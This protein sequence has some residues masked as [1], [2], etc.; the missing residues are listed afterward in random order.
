MKKAI[1]YLALGIL[2][3]AGQ[4]CEKD[5]AFSFK[6]D[7]RIYFSYPRAL[8]HLGRE[9]DK[10][11]DSLNFSFVTLPDD[12]TFDTVWIKLK[13]VGERSETD[14]L[15]AVQ[16]VR[17]SSSAVE[18]V[19]FEPLKPSYVFRK[20]LGVDSMP[21]IVYREHLKTTLSKNILLK[22]KETEDFKIGFMEYA[23]FKVSISD[24]YPVPDDWYLVSGHLGEYHYMKY[25]KW[26]ELTGTTGFGNS[27]SFRS[28]YCGLIKEY[29]NTGNIIDP[30][31]GERVTCNL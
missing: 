29:F 26:I 15:Y 21:L 1:I 16:V 18:G 14:K 25:E 13:R 27:A 3:F 7:D 5:P 2:L 12:V 22:I 10:E 11:L 31:T 6:G 28:Y 23:T 4:S 17:D 9:T 19:D 24:L 8:D 20:K 30:I